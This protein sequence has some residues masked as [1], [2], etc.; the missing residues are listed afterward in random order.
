MLDGR[1]T[2]AALAK[3][4]HL[5]EAPTWRRVKALE[6][7]KVIQGYRAVIDPRKLGYE[8]VAFVNIRFSSHDPALQAAFEQQVRQIDDVLWCHNVSGSVD[9]LLCVVARSLSEYGD[10]V[11]AR[12]RNLPGVTAIESSFSLRT[13]KEFAGF[14]LI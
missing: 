6:D 11:S 9:F 12:L 3:Q 2:N 4:V 7:D 1:Q 10:M 14:P 13:V 5:A 8:V